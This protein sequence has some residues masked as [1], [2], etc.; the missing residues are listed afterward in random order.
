M[1]NKDEF[2]EVLQG[3]ILQY[4]SISKFVEKSSLDRT[5]ISKYIN[6]KLEHP[7]SPEIL[8]KISN[9]SNNITSY[10]NLMYICGYLNDNECGYLKNIKSNV[11]NSKILHSFYFI[12][13][14]N[15]DK[16]GQKKVKEYIQDLIDTNKYNKEN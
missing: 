4:G 9:N 14:N 6:K 1:F 5:Y 3:I 2:A 15:L 8:R 13:Y 12:Q 7:P 16:I 11:N 10:I